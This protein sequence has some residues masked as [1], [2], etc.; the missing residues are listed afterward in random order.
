M[1]RR[2]ALILGALVLSPLGLP[3]AEGPTVVR[4]VLPGGLRLLVR[5]DPNAQV[6]TVSLQVRSGSRYD[7]PETAGLS[8]L[9]QRVM[10][11][12]TARRSARQIVEAAEDIGG[13]LEASADVEHAEIRGG[14]LAAHARTLLDLIAEV[15]LS[16][17]FPPD[18][19]ERE[20]RLVLSQI[21]T[22]AETPFALA[23]DTL[24]AQ[25]YG[26]HP[27]ALPTLGRKASV[28][29]LGRE[30]L[31]RHHRRVYRAGS[32]VLAVSGGVE[33]ESLRRHVQRVFARTP[34]GDVDDPPPRS[35]R[36]PRSG[37]CSIGRPS[38]L[39]S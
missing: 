34:E 21:Q 37:A 4:D 2:L 15:A 1:R 33:R 16:P 14:A 26:S 36:H 11:R 20:R 8:N 18:E 19:V 3:A 17:A 35:Q 12:G 10:L 13:S 9:V 7:T 30:D 22:R 27:L 23:L 28:E 5:D 31:I 29:R 6:A 32:M 24:T 38:R 39:R 25:L